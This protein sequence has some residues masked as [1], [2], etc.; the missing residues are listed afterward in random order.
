MVNNQ[1]LYRSEAS[2]RAVMEAYEAVLAAGPVPYTTQWV[3]TRLGQTHVV[4]GGPESGE[5]VLLFHGWN[6]SAAG[7]GDE[8]PFL[9]EKYRVYMPDI[10]GHA[11][12]S[13]AIRPSTAGST[14]PDW[15]A[16][17]MDGL[18]LMQAHVM[19]ISGGGW[20]ALKTAA[21]LPDRIHK[22]VVVNPD[23]LAR[24]RLRPMLPAIPAVLL[25]SEAR[26]KRMVRVWAAADS[27]S[28]KL[29]AFAQ[30][31]I[32]MMQ[33]FKTQNNPGL[34]PDAELQ[35]ITRPTCLLIGEHDIFD[36]AKGLARAKQLIPGLAMAEHLPKT[37]HILLEA[38]TKVVAEKV[39]RFLHE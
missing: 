21:Y 29:E 3:E 31:M 2:Y 27:D 17:V 20:L 35:R 34:I 1:A 37:G 9:F 13:A 25:K 11:G 6:G 33:H 19:G 36:S 23:G 15:V 14:F 18:G 22:V 24:L 26:I 39:M 12:K 5:P 7:T 38:S 16:E 10:V 30:G 28:P 8:F 32:F 4:V